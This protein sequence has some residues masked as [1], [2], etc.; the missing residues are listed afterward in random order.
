MCSVS[1]NS[2]RGYTWLA[3]GY[4]QG[5]PGLS[6]RA[7]IFISEQDTGVERVLSKF[8]D[9]TELGGAVGFLEG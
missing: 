4:Q 6:P 9:S 1:F 3:D 2:K 7:N 8:G 5:A